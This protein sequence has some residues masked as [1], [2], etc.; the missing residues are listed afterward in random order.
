MIDHFYLL[1][2]VSPIKMILMSLKIFK[3]LEM[4]KIK[5]ILK[6]NYIDEDIQRRKVLLVCASPDNFREKDIAKK[7]LDELHKDDP[8]WEKKTG[9]DKEEDFYILNN[10]PYLRT[11]IVGGKKIAKTEAWI[12]EENYLKGYLGDEGATGL[13][14]AKGPFDAIIFMNCPI[15]V[16]EIS[17][18]VYRGKEELI[19]QQINKNLKVGGKVV[20][21]PFKEGI[22]LGDLSFQDLLGPFSQMK[23]SEGF[24]ILTKLR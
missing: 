17:K 24:G 10:H 11:K 4:E 21:N 8:E 16:C 22:V 23:E 20:L 13:L 2:N 5:R 18:S 6:G 15:Y 9:K 19:S 12:S 3:K 1:L 7:I 14:K